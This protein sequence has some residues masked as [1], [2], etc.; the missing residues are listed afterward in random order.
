[1]PF[2]SLTVVNNVEVGCPWVYSIQLFPIFG[3]YFLG[4]WGTNVFWDSLGIM[5]RHWDCLQ[6]LL[7]RVLHWVEERLS[8]WSRS[9]RVTQSETL[10][11]HFSVFR[12]LLQLVL[13]KDS[14][15]TD[16]GISELKITKIQLI[17]IWETIPEANQQTRIMDSVWSFIFRR[18]EQ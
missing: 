4:S 11:I 14:G 6:W 15:H 2:E 10:G 16:L 17:S 5:R 18:E 12:N 1:M 13:S 7:P 3:H 9:P 8:G